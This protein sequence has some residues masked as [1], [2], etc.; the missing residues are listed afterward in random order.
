[1]YGN[2]NG[3]PKP[4]SVDEDNLELGS[5]D[6]MMS[7]T[8]SDEE[9][10]TVFVGYNLGR[11]T[12]VTDVPLVKLIEWSSVANDP[13][14][15]EIAQR[16]LD[17]AHARGLGVYMLKGLVNSAMARRILMNKPIPEIF[18]QILRQLGT[19]P[20]FSLQPFVANIRDINPEKPSVRAER[21]QSKNNETRG[22][23]VYLPRHFRWWMIDGQHRLVGGQTTKEFLEYV[24]KS[25][26]YPARNNLFT[27]RGKVSPEEMIVWMEALECARSFA[28]V[29]VELHLGLSIEQE[30]QL[31]HDLNNLGKKVTRSL[32]LKFDGSNPITK[33]IDDVLVGEMGLQDC[34]NEQTDWA[35]DNGCLPRKDIVAINAIAFLNKGNITGATPAIIEPRVETVSQMWTA[36]LK[37][38]GVNQA[39][40]K[41][42]TVAAQPVVLKAIAKIVFDLAFSNRRPDNGDTLL[43]SAFARLGEVDFG[44]D[45]PMWRF[46]EMSQE[47]RAGAGIDGLAAYLPDQGQVTAEANRDLGSFQGGVMRFGVRHN[48]IFPILADMIRWKLGLPNRHVK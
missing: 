33:F 39:G 41:L 17:L 11:M 47:D 28:S 8:A 13:E 34:E 29:K 38:P 31:F 36:I 2:T 40:A 23:Q 16:P 35:Q 10:F 19:Q 32:S 48:D 22:F 26:S 15:G 4:M 24:T 45:N 44:H 46:Y 43:D 27:G 7:F 6:S 3:M 1:M 25:G 37:L 20:Y 14:K 5:L 18:H 42:A 21:I 9:P 12:W 30:R